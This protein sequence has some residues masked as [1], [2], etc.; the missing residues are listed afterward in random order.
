MMAYDSQRVQAA[1]RRK[2]EDAEFERQEREAEERRKKLGA[3]ETWDHGFCGQSDCPCECHP[4][5]TPQERMYLRR[6]MTKDRCVNVS[7]RS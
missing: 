7:A 5:L 3:C 1:A 6:L 4:E 2:K